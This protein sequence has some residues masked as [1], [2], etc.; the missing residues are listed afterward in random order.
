MRNQIYWKTLL[1]MN[2][3]KLVRNCR[4]SMLVNLKGEEQISIWCG[5]QIPFAVIRQKSD[6]SQSTGPE[7]REPGQ[8]EGTKNADSPQFKRLT[9]VKHADERRLGTLKKTSTS[10]NLANS[11]LLVYGTGQLSLI[12]VE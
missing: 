6:W 5:V 12:M 4:A 2:V 11:G 7:L 1:V 8:R 9:A 3:I 10:I